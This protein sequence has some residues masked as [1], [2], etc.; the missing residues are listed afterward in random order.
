MSLSAIPTIDQCPACTS[1]EVEPFLDILDVPVFC[2]ILCETKGEALGIPRGN[3][4]LTFCRKCGHI[5]NAQ[6]DGQRVQYSQN[7]ENSLHFSPTFQEFARN[8]ASHLI[9]KYQLFGKKI[10][11]IG[12]GQGTFLNLL[13]ELG[14]NWG[15]GFDKSFRHHQSASSLSDRITLVQ[16]DFSEQASRYEADFTCCRHVLEHIAQPREFLSVV[17]RSV[18]SRKD[19]LIYFEIPNGLFTIRELAIWDIIYEHFS[20]FTRHSLI[21]LFKSCGFDVRDCFEVYEGQFIGIEAVPMVGA[22]EPPGNGLVELSQLYKEVVVFAERFD[23]KMAAW[24]D[25]L[26]GWE[27]RRQRS[28]LWGAGSK[29]VTFLNLLK[30]QELVEYVVDM[31]PRKQDKFIAGSGQQIVPPAF[32]QDFQPDLIILMN[33]IYREE[34][35][36]LVNNLGV[37]A[38]IMTV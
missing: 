9:E 26:E 34:V 1:Q 22:G 32:L 36:R 28:I 31:N 25:K 15:V 21:R 23:R 38:T 20:Y 7:Y 13:C 16:D 27:S 33:S 19:A 8:L 24:R 4:Q 35:Q 14:N 17:R 37:Q 6:F 5:Y 29:G 30:I 3:I 18:R 10:I 2:N 11:E 12:C